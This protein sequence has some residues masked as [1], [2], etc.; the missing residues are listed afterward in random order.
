MDPGA[1]CYQ[2]G[3]GQAEGKES[4]GIGEKKVSAAVDD[5]VLYFVQGINLLRWQWEG[6]FFHKRSSCV[7]SNPETERRHPNI[8]RKFIVKRQELLKK[9]FIGA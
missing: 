9:Q 8:C 3:D 6:V 7:T 2:R 5:L 4:P 1:T